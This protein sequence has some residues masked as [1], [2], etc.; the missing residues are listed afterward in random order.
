MCHSLDTTFIQEIGFFLCLH[1]KLT[2]R[3]QLITTIERFIEE[4]Y[5]LEEPVKVDVRSRLW[6]IGNGETRV[7]SQLMF[8]TCGKYDVK[9]VSSA[10]SIMISRQ[11]LPGKA[12]FFP[13]NVNEYGVDA[14]KKWLNKHDTFFN[15]IKHVA[16]TNVN[17]ADL[18]VLLQATSNGYTLQEMFLDSGIITIE[19]SN[20]KG[21]FHFLSDNQKALDT[22]T[23]DIVFPLLLNFKRDETPTILGRP[24]RKKDYGFNSDYVQAFVV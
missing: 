11:L 6:S 4:Q 7:N 9:L 2:N 16:N 23:D 12:E 22:F 10:L 19:P 1:P 3:F 17:T 24:L 5:S 13:L 20:I 15:N 18:E 8:L 21:K 14:Y